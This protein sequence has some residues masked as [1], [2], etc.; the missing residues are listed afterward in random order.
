LQKL[1]P[2]SVLALH[3]HR[4]SLRFVA[5]NVSLKT[6]FEFIRAACLVPLAALLLLLPA[7][8]ADTNAAPD[9]NSK[10]AAADAVSVQ[11]F[12]RSYLQLQE[13]LHNT[14]LTIEK[15]RLEAQAAATSNSVVMDDRWRLMEKTFANERL[16]QVR[17][18]ERSDRM[19]LSAA[20][21]FAAVG[22]LVLLLAAFLQWTSVNRFAAAAASL[23]AAHPPQGLGAGDAPLVPAHALEQSNA[24]FLGLIERLEQRIHELEMPVKTPQALPESS[25]ANGEAGGPA[26]PD[27]AGL[28]KLLLG[29]S[30][31]L[32][33]LDKPEAAL[34]CLDEVL[35]LDPGNA[36]ALVKTGTIMERLQRFD[37]AIQCYDRAIAH[38]NSMTMAYLYKGSVFN[39]MERY[40][41]A[42]ACYEQ[43]LK[44]G[45]TAAPE[46]SP[47]NKPQIGVAVERRH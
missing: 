44:P 5:M 25:S 42:L 28:I 35:T 23:A 16:E 20:G 9:V 19:I 37:E 10:T 21:V 15:N 4:V 13:Q 47:S 2:A 22:F 45:K 40:S 34:G 1:L 7:L 43:A 31:T 32:I 17:G 26:E 11:D 29:K 38:D 3:F 30:Q 46:T 24:R 14:L 12:L 33:K 41:E 6:G 27:K 18:I 8:A 36:D 39:R